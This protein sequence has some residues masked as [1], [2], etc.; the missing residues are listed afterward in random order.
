M[1]NTLASWVLDPIE[2]EKQLRQMHGKC[3]DDEAD[4][5]DIAVFIVDIIRFAITYRTEK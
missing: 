1:T 2:I 5:H 3:L 4:R